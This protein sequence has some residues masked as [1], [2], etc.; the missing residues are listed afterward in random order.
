MVNHNANSNQ[1]P[2][3]VLCTG[4]VL[5]FITTFLPVIKELIGTWIH[6]EDQ[7]HGLLILPISL[8]IVFRD[9]NRLKE[10]KISPGYAG[11]L[12]VAVS[13]AIYILSYFARISSI[14]NISLVITIWAIVWSL[15]GKSIFKI[16]LFPMGLLLL[17]VPVPAQ[18]YA[19]ATIPL[20]LMVSKASALITGLLGI[21]VWR[22]GNVLHIPG[23]TL[24]VVQACSGLR[25]L[26][27]L[28]T[29]CALFGYFTLSSNWLR[30]LLVISSVPIAI[31]VNI[32]RVVIIIVA[33]Q[34]MELDLSKGVSHTIF[35]VLIFMFSMLIITI[36]KGFLSKWDAKQT[37]A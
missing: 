15:F 13:I 19:F 16:V 21:P 1:T 32:I 2:N 5:V 33:Y 36:T 34:Y 20:Q 25:S 3:L 31:V 29:L 17:M 23:V 35:G 26:M 12:L 27:S 8:Y 30:C 18:L 28:V 14:K 11:W 9:R 7:S 10:A 24:A 22:E 6:S 4:L 37:A